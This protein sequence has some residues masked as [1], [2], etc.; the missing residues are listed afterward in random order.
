MHSTFNSFS[1]INVLTSW[2]NFY[3]LKPQPQGIPVAVA[4]LDK[5]GI[6]EDFN[7]SD[8]M[9]KDVPP[10][11]KTASIQTRI[12][13]LSQLFRKHAD[14]TWDWMKKWV[15]DPSLKEKTVR[16][17]ICAVWIS[18]TPK[19]CEVL[20]K[21]SQSAYRCASFAEEVLNR[22]RISLEVSLTHSCQVDLCFARF[23][24]TGDMGLIAKLIDTLV[25]IESKGLKMLN[26]QSMILAIADYSRAYPQI[27]PFI[28]EYCKNS[29]QP[30]HLILLCAFSPM[31]PQYTVSELF[32]ELSQPE[33]MKQAKQATAIVNLILQDTPKTI[34]TL[35]AL[36]KMASEQF[37]RLICTRTLSEMK[38][39][40]TSLLNEGVNLRTINQIIAFFGYELYRIYDADSM[41]IDIYPING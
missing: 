33:Q 38:C 4:F 10:N 31:H 30:I 5:E 39:D 19:G 12:F 1:S 13:M 2:V 28:F 11:E 17:L 25:A 16:G 35:E 8:L 29:L 24:V 15:Q 22:P 14:L 20:R 23:S 34:Y 41:A 32:P 9:S 36:R 26:I 21:I 18:D 40:M 7:L 6:V 3:Y 27:K 37:K